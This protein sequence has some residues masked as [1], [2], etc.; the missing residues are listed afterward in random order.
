M[1]PEADHSGDGE[2]GGNALVAEYALGLLDA[3][4]HDRVARMIAADPALRA[5]L[6]MWRNRLSSFDSEFAEQ[7][8]PASSW[9]KIEGRLFGSAQRATSFW[10]N[11]ALWR[12]L[13]AGALAVAVVAIGVNVARPPVPSP[14]EFATQLVAALQ[15]QEGSGVEFVA[16]YDSTKGSVKLIGLSGEAVAE[17]D[18]ELWYIEPDQQPVSMGVVPVDAQLEIAVTPEA[19]ARLDEGTVLAVTLEQKGG[20]PT[21]APQGTLV[22]AGPAIKV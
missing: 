7:A 11:L 13:F 19:R 2:E 20:S 16:F 8:A 1:S 6:Q 10:D 14:D 4:E 22:S 17:K 21:G 5:E 9:D 12:G 3:A 18:Y 15:A